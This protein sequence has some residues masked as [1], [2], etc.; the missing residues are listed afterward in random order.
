MGCFWEGLSSVPALGLV[1]AWEW[2][3][4]LLVTATLVPLAFPS[5]KVTNHINYKVVLRR[6]FHLGPRG[7]CHQ[8]TTRGLITSAFL[9]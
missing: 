6:V 2:E 9:M 3:H 4:P 8:E 7:L 1:G 5:Q